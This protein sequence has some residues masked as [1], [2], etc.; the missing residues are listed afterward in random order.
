MIGDDS[1]TSASPSSPIEHRERAVV[2]APGDAPRPPSPAGRAGTRRRRRR[3]PAACARRPASAATSASRS[4]PSAGPVRGV[5]D[6]DRHLDQRRRARRPT[7]WSPGRCRRPAGNAARPGPTTAPD[8]VAS[9]SVVSLGGRVNGV[10]R[11]RRPPAAAPIGVEVDLVLDGLVPRHP[12]H[13]VDVERLDRLEAVAR[14]RGGLDSGG[15]APAGTGPGRVR[16]GV[17]AGIDDDLGAHGR[18]SRTGPRGP[19]PAGPAHRTAIAAGSSGPMP[20]RGTARS[21]RTAR[22]R[23]PPGRRRSGSGRRAHRPSSPAS[24]SS[25][26]TASSQVGQGSRGL[27][28]QEGV[29]R[30]RDSRTQ[31]LLGKYGPSPRATP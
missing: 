1:I 13:A 15:A 23:P 31:P 24:F 14:R 7:R 4:A 20:G 19:R 16:V 9:S 26:S 11:G 27:E 10:R 28:P 2:A 5:L 3:R 22:R 30:L 12:P 8:G 17:A 25:C 18:P 6:L 29:E 21:P